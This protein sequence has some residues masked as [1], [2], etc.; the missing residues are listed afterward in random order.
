VQIPV[1]YNKTLL[2]WLS[3]ISEKDLIGIESG[4]ELEMLEREK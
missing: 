1:F 3:A 4:I 2:L